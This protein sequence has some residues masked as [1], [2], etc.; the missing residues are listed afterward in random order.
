MFYLVEIRIFL[1]SG[2]FLF[3]I[4]FY[5]LSFSEQITFDFIRSFILF[6]LFKE[7]W[8]ASLSQAHI[9]VLE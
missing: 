7:I 5:P 8:K 1:T 9:L 2:L 4:R 3:P 6:L